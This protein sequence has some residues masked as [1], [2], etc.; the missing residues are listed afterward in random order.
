MEERAFDALMSRRAQHAGRLGPLLGTHAW[1][2]WAGMAQ[3][4]A[5]VDVAACR[6]FLMVGCGPLPDSLLYLHEETAVES[7]VG[8][9][10][11]PQALRRAR[12]LSAA[13]GLER[14]EIR[15]ADARDFDYAGFDL[16]CCSAFL[17]PRREVL[18]RVAATARPDC[19][20]LLRDPVLTGKLFFES[21]LPDPRFEVCAES[22]APPRRFMLKYYSLRRRPAPPPGTRDP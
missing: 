22:S 5:L 7:L 17:T 1:G 8:I 11:D 15:D 2:A 16:I 6:R 9:D 21:V 18:A 19:A 10:R 12:E 3:S 20:I 14:I 13:F 4:L